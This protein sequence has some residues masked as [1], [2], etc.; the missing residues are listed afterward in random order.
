MAVE[1]MVT[2][3]MV[4]ENEVVEFVEVIDAEVVMVAR[5]TEMVMTEVMRYQWWLQGEVVMEKVLMP[6][7]V[8]VVSD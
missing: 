2:E 5:S 3:M 7:V 4:I 8:A 1:M 6:T